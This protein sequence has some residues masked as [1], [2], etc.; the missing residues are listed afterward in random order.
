MP[1]VEVD[2]IQN[3][4]RGPEILEKK[5]IRKRS[6]WPKIIAILIIVAFFGVTIFSSSMVF[7]DREL[8]DN[9]SKINFFQQV[10][11][12]IAAKSK[13][14]HGEKND[15]I[16]LLILGIGGA[17]HDGGNLTDT[18]ILGSFKPSINQAAMMSIPRDL[19][20]KSENL[21]WLK[22][23]AINAYAEKSSPGSGGKAAADEMSRLLNDDVYYYLTVDFDGFEKLIDEFGGVEVEVENNLTDY[24]YPILGQ[25]DAYPIES[26][27]ETLKIKKG[28]QSLDGKTALKYARSRHALGVEGS[29]FARSKRQQKI[30]A[31]LKEKIFSASTLFSPKKI[32]A[33]L[34]TYNQHISTNLE[35]WEMLK[36][37]ELGKQADGA[38]IINRSLTNGPGGLLHDQI[39]EEGAYVLLPNDS[40]YGAI[41]SLWQNIFDD[42]TAKAITDSDTAFIPPP[43]IKPNATSTPAQATSTPTLEPE[44]DFTQERATIEIQ[45]GTFVAGWA[46]REFERLK[47]LGFKVLKFGNAPTR[48]YTSVTIYDLSRG[49]YP[50]TI[51]ELEKIY[52]TTAADKIPAS[53]DSM[54]NILIVL[55][56]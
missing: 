41:R 10:G 13:K 48:D 50:L 4:P 18:I 44:T 23:N 5:P 56:K 30:L 34:E 53:I 19:M 46:T 42:A 31:A 1:K 15:R 20:V 21:G 45:N 26:R 6:I 36:L 35:I 40:S 38:K 2:F 28:L 24:Q 27:Y 47:E 12:L 8:L 29:D 33:L 16:N 54:V 49:K 7:S 14:L 39:T 3:D 55:G 51:K 17:G 52:N 25:E 32:N 22:I 43:I 11:K 9:L 37:Y